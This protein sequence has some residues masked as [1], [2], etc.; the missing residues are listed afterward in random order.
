MHKLNQ[1]KA[2]MLA[3]SS[4]RWQSDAEVLDVVLRGA[5]GAALPA[6]M[7]A[8]SVTTCCKII[9]EHYFHFSPFFFFFFF[10]LQKQK[11]SLDFFR[12]AKMGTN[13]RLS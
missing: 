11:S 7:L 9:A 13:V 4:K 2:E 5:W 8:A 6:W 12:L 1:G 10:F 3:D